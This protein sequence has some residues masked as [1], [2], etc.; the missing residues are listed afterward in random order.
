MIIRGFSEF[1]G[2]DCTQC[3]LKCCA[4]EYDLPL[5]TQ[6]SANLQQMY[7][8]S[9]FFI[10]SSS[11]SNWLIRGDSCPFLTTRGLCKLHSTVLKPLSCHIYPLT[12]WRIDTNHTLVWINPC[13]GTS[14]YWV[15]DQTFQISDQFLSNLVEL[16][17]GEFNTYWGEQI[18]KDNPFS[19]IDKGRV[20]QEVSFFQKI[21]YNEF[22]LDLMNLEFPNQFSKLVDFRFESLNYAEDLKDIINSV[23]HWLCWS[24]IGLQLT[25]INSKLIFLVAAQ[26]ILSYA[27]PIVDEINHDDH[28]RLLQQLGSFLATAILPAFWKQI[29][30]KTHLKRLREFSITVQRILLGNL[31]QQNL[32]EYSQG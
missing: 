15:A 12:I 22:L 6:E 18:D 3:W 25:F 26:W 23:L 29:E 1:T 21:S 10:K 4:T 31:P 19:G 13:R 2:Y 11:E 30:N 27:T 24:P 8:L 20:K 32:I 14:F 16:A 7:P 28:K 17:K 9:S 5:L